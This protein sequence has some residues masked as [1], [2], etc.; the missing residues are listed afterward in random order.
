MQKT[1]T[2]VLCIGILIFG[3]GFL[4]PLSSQAALVWDFELDGT[5]LFGTGQFTVSDNTPGSLE[6]FSFSGEL[7]QHPFQVGLGDIIFADW[8]IASDQF[9]SLTIDTQQVPTGTFSVFA[10]LHLSHILT[11]TVG[12]CQDLLGTNCNNS[13]LFPAS[14]TSQSF[15]LQ[16][17]PVP[18][19]GTALL[20]APGLLGLAGYRWRQFRQERSQVG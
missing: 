3:L 10:T 19:P 9:T 14:P 8:S 2:S 20:I 11:S 17:A 1:I 13:N 15:T 6:A 4:T 18:I 5:D 12:E 16:P 7:F